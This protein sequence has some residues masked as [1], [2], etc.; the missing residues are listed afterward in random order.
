MK[1]P[2]GGLSVTRTTLLRVGEQWLIDGLG[3]QRPR[4]DR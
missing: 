3:V 1:S 2:R 4:Y